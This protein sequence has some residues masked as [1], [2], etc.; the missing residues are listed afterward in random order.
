MIIL[1]KELKTEDLIN[2]MNHSWGGI[3]WERF[4]PFCLD[5]PMIIDEVSKRKMNEILIK[6]LGQDLQEVTNSHFIGRLEKHSMFLMLCGDEKYIILDD[7]LK[8]YISEAEIAL[9]KMKT[10][11]ER[12]EKR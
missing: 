7:Q 12:C 9:G 3:T 2:E 4:N 11:V 1:P 6:L 10:R 5:K 8:N